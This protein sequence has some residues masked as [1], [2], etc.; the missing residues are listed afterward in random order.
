MVQPW[1]GID[2]RR[3]DAVG[4]EADIALITMQKGSPAGVT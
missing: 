4:L 3:G 2:L 1:S